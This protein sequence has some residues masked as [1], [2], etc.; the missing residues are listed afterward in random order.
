MIQVVEG[1]AQDIAAMMTI[2]EDAFDPRFG[3]TW[4]A[5]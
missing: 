2:M 1:D 4:T 3:E 5:A